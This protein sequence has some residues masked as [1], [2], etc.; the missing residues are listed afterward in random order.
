MATSWDPRILT[1]LDDSREWLVLEGDFE[2]ESSMGTDL[3]VLGEGC[4]SMGVI[5]VV[6]WKNEKNSSGEGLN[7]EEGDA[8]RLKSTQIDPNAPEMNV[9]NISNIARKDEGERTRG[10]AGRPPL[11]R[12]APPCQ[13][14]L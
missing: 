13:V 12:P 11:G 5:L 3:E 2:L 1:L 14:W 6:E 9:Y 10:K 8:S 4:T 7:E